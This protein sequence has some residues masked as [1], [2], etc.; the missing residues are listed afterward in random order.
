M[1]TNGTP[2]KRWCSPGLLDDP[3]ALAIHDI[4]LAR[5]AASSSNPASRRNARLAHEVEVPFGA[6]VEFVLVRLRAAES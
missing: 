2:G 1:R 4:V 5:R 3:F 6:L